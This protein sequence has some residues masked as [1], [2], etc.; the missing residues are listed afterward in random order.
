MTIQ[1]ICGM[2]YMLCIIV[3]FDE[4]IASYVDYLI[5]YTFI[6]IINF[7]IRILNIVL[8]PVFWLIA[9]IQKY[10]YYRAL[11]KEVMHILTTMNYDDDE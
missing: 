7:F 8:F 9:Q 5:M 3:I 2:I 11:Q 10:L 1:F 4:V 6:A